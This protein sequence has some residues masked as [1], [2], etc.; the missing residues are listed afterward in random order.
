MS[1][2]PD[3]LEDGTLDAGLYLLDLVRNPEY[4]FSCREIAEVCGCSTRNISYIEARALAKLK[5]Q[6]EIR[7]RYMDVPPPPVH[8][9]SDLLRQIIA[10]GN[11][12][13]QRQRE[14]DL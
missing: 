4:K 12:D 14:Q 1:G 6:F 5:K 8:I 9:P 2:A 13:R 11:Y 10:Y 7:M 3:N